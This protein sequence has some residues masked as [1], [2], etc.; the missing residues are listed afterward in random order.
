MKLCSLRAP[1][2][3]TLVNLSILVLK[4]SKF[5]MINL[6]IIHHLL[7]IK[8]GFKL[9]RFQFKQLLSNHPVIVLKFHN[10]QFDFVIKSGDLKYPTHQS[11][12]I[13]LVDHLCPKQSKFNLKILKDHKIL[14]IQYILGP[15]SKLLRRDHLVAIRVE[16]HN[17]ED[18]K[19]MTKLTHL[20]FL[21]IIGQI[22][23]LST[24]RTNSKCFVRGFEFF[25]IIL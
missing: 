1:I 6:K 12:Q 13:C 24:I 25:A 10:H 18:P 23:I 19:F 17:L 22:Q 9:T 21:K 5:L 4:K 3:L 20:R 16:N 8:V 15:M 2:T 11:K 7:A 14:P